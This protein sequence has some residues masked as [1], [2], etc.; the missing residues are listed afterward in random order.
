ME[1]I[2]NRFGG[3]RCPKSCL[4]SRKRSDEGP[5]TSK[6][7]ATPLPKIKVIVIGSI[8]LINNFG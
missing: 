8:V 1:V 6:K 3:L 7:K 5:A 4:P 2:T